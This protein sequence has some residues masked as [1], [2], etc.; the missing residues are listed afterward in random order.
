MLCNKII[1]KLTL[2]YPKTSIG[3]LV[4]SQIVRYST[5]SWCLIIPAYLR[6]SLFSGV[7]NER[8]N[9]HNTSVVGGEPEATEVKRDRPAEGGSEIYAIFILCFVLVVF[10]TFY[11]NN[12]TKHYFFSQRVH[13][14]LPNEMLC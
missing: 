13:M 3:N 2:F 14:Y 9:T 4:K 6:F 11:T 10:Q 8:G 12:Y 1:S 5:C 7:Y